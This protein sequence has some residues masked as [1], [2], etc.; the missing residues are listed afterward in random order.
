MGH[1]SVWRALGGPADVAWFGIRRA[2]RWTPGLVLR[3]ML[4]SL[5]VA[6]TPAAQVL[7]VS[8]LVRAADLGRLS[9]VV[10]PLVILVLLVGASQVAAELSMVTNQRLYL[11]LSRRY[12]NELL[13]AVARLSPQELARAEMSA[14]IQGARE[15]VSDLASLVNAVMSSLGAVVTAGTLCAS[16]WRI[17]PI[18]GVLVPLALLPALLVYARTARKQE[19]IWVPYGKWRRRAAYQAEQL[20]S[21]RS[22]TELAALGT[23]GQ[24]A[25]AADDSLAEA[26][27]LMDRI[28]VVL[29][30]G[31]ALGGPATA[32]LLAGALVGI[33]IGGGG[34]AGVAA[35]ILG[36]IAGTT[37]TRVAGFAYGELVA[38]VPKVKT[39]RA[40]LADIDQ[41][42]DRTG[43]KV[44][45]T[46]ERLS[47]TEVTVTYPNQDRP[48]LTEFNLDVKAGTMVALVGVNGAGK[49]TA[50]NALL[51]ILDLDHGRVEI[52]GVDAA[53]LSP[54]RRL[55]HFGLLTQ[56]F[57]RYDLT[58]RDSVRLGT[59][60][61]VSDEQIWAAL[62]AAHI[63]DLV[64]GLPEGLDTQLGPQFEGIGLSGG[65]WQ[66][67]ALARIHLRDAGIWILDE[68]TSAID[69]EAEQQIFAELQRDKSSRIT[70]VT[71]H[72]AWTLRDMNHIY[73]LDH[74]AIVEHGHYE[75]L[76]SANGR[77][78]EIFASQVNAS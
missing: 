71:S 78:A 69:A 38:T 64:R 30:R 51:G 44:T 48:A 36:V 57:G 70:V 61:P 9:A 39:Y 37:A 54:N 42:T 25:T 2:W 62:E 33:V 1:L 12:L 43:H 22:A 75:D 6:V 27:R 8:S 65:Q 40:L 15:S 49:T 13:Q 53:T 7:M 72:R 46:A 56:E 34:G 24:V 50:I 63:G 52:D 60:E 28:L 11:A 14:R 5:V 67:L 77:F 35:G 26:D 66:R 23:G 59:P 19:E 55:G 4:M 74:G 18:A 47:A 10:P 73:V 58:I 3:L 20:V 32:V 31:T 76:I 41:W 68:P 45:H 29:G 16:V 21:Q 17:N